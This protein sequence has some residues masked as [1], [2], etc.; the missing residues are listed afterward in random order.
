LFSSLVYSPEAKLQFTN[1]RTITVDD[2]EDIRPAENL[3][4]NL[5]SKIMFGAGFGEVKKWVVGAEITLQQNSD[6]KNRFD[7]ITG[8]KFENSTRYSL[9][10]YFIPN[11]N[12]FSSYLKKITYRGGLRYENTGMVLQNKSIED[13]AVNLGVSLPLSGTFSN[14]NVGFEMGKRGTKYFN[15]IEENYFNLSVGLSFSDKWFER[16]KFN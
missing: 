6:L 15:L 4:L 16:R 13:F 11:Y 1:E 10:G 9:G 12:S 5:P 3:K 2:Q 7:D 14:V 8:V